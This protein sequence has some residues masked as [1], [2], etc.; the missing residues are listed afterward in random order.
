MGIQQR[1]QPEPVAPGENNSSPLSQAR[2]AE[3]SGDLLDFLLN[4]KHYLDHKEHVGYIC[5]ASLLLCLIFK[6][7]YQSNACT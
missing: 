3:I 7:Y 5:E 1:Q 2:F 6:C 4:V